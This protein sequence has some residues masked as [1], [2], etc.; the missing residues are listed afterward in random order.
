MIKGVPG[1]CPAPD[2]AHPTPGSWDET[3]NA[4]PAQSSS[5]PHLPRT[6]SLPRLPKR[7]GP[8]FT[9]S[10]LKPPQP[11]PRSPPAQVEIEI[12]ATPRDGE[13]RGT[14]LPSLGR[15]EEGEEKTAGDS[16]FVSRSSARPP[17]LVALGPL[18]AAT[19]E[20]SVGSVSP[21][22]RL[23]PP[24][25]ERSRV[26]RVDGDVVP[27]PLPPLRSLTPLPAMPR[28]ASHAG[29]VGEEEAGMGL[30]LGVGVGRGSPVQR[31]YGGRLGGYS[32][33]GVG[34]VGGMVSHLSLN[35]SPTMGGRRTQGQGQG[36][37]EV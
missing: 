21:P 9:P 26:R 15:E 11:V 25:A 28:A 23:P 10:L 14:G 30:G 33:Y 7:W 6:S 16:P 18:P 20:P 27:S 36:E 13:R 32:P 19:P 5:T 12:A 35:G 37:G 31:G 29:V 3:V 24:P 8:I 17:P 4:S 22:P 2:P 34:G 1:R